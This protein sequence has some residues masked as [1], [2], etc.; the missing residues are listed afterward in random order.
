MS[1]FEES[2]AEMDG[3]SRLRN[4]MQ[5]RLHLCERAAGPN[6]ALQCGITTR[7]PQPAATDPCF[8]LRV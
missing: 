4:K 8:R 6:S 1:R 7:L 3:K 2:N 5:D